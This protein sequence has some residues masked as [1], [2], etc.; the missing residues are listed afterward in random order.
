MPQED[1][2]DPQVLAAERGD[3]DPRDQPQHTIM[4]ERN[5]KPDQDPIKEALLLIV[6]REYDI[7]VVDALNALGN[8]RAQ[9]VVQEADKTRILDALGNGTDEYVWVPGMSWVDA[10][11]KAIDFT[12]WHGQNSMAEPEELLLYR[13]LG[14]LEQ[15][16]RATDAVGEA[17]QIRARFAELEAS[18]GALSLVVEQ[19]DK[20]I[21]R[22]RETLDAIHK[23]IFSR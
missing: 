12:R 18:E 5:F 9:V 14:T 13:E 20:T 23:A 11:C 17:R 22:F 8:I 19:Q 1:F 2:S 15:L 21:A 7:P 16:S 10:A 4:T 3:L 6:D